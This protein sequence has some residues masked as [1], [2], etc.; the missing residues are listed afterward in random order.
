VPAAIVDRHEALEGDEQQRDAFVLRLRHREVR[1]HA[2]AV[3]V[4]PR[5]GRS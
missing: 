5:P 2:L 3:Q 1:P 4:A